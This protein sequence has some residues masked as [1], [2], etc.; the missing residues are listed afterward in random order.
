MNIFHCDC[1]DRAIDLDEDSG[2]FDQ[3]IFCCDRCC[4]EW[5]ETVTG[6]KPA[7]TSS[8]EARERMNA[9]VRADALLAE[10]EAQP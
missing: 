8:N 10:K 2:V 4:D 6:V 5:Q 9:V 3:G 7:R 1:C